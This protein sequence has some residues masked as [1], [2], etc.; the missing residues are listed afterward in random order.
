MNTSVRI[1]SETV[2]YLIGKVSNKLM[3]SREM[4]LPFVDF[5]DFMEALLRLLDNRDG[6]RL[7]AAGHV[8]PDVAMAADR[9]H[10]DLKETLAVSPFTGDPDRTLE[11]IST[12]REII[13]VANPNRVTGANYSLADLEMLARAVPEG[14]LMVDEHYYDFYGISGLP[15]LERHANIIVIRSLTTSFGIRSDESGYVVASKDII[16]ALKEAYSWDRISRMTYKILSTCLMNYEAMETRLKL[17]HD[18]SLRIALGLNRLKIQNRLTATDFLLLR[19]ADP[20]RVGNYL[21]SSRVQVENLDGYPELKNYIRYDIQ[22]EL[23]N[24]IMINAFKRMPE[25]YYRMDNLDKR[26]IKM[27][28]PGQ[29]KKTETGAETDMTVFDRG[30]IEIREKETVEKV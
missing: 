23:S 21:A 15:L 28:K 12:G 8:T 20:V 30:R 19:V 22:S 13:Y 14:T 27:R 4:V 5:T 7:V 11:E 25:A 2:N 29:G 10:L 16:N 3:V 1:D 9:A 6:R 26:F 18:E 24:D 17:L